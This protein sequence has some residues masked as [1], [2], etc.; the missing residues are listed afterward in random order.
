MADEQVNVI[1]DKVA[2]IEYEKYIR[3]K[4]KPYAIASIFEVNG[5]FAQV[6]QV[7]SV[8]FQP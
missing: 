2:K 8:V 5:H 3:P 4:V 7:Y 6:S 1:L